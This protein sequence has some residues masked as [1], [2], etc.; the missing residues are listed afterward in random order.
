MARTLDD[1]LARRVRALFLNS[2]ATLEMAPAVASLMARELG[3]DEAWINT[4]LA[5]FRAMAAG[6]L[7]ESAVVQQ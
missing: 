3:R 6:Y 5:E 2:R 1:V 4:Q 7:P